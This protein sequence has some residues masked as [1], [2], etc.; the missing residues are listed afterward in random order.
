MVGR[1]RELGVLR[2]VYATAASAPAA[3]VVLGEAGIGKSRLVREF[4]DELPPGRAIWGHCLQLAG[5][6]LPF[7]A[8]ED[9][10]HQLPGVEDADEEP[11]PGPA[12]SRQRQFERWLDR[13]ESLGDDSGAA[14]LVIEDLH[15][16]D[17]STLDFI[18]YVGRSL[19]RRRLLLILTRRDDQLQVT[20][21]VLESLAELVR[22]PHVVP[23][24]LERLSASEASELA[25]TVCGDAVHPTVA[26]RLYDRSEGNPYLL[27][28][29][30]A[31]SGEVASHVQ[32]VLLARV[33]GFDEDARLLIRLA[34]VAGVSVND[35]VLWHTSG[36]DADRYLSAVRASV[37]AGVLLTEGGRYVFRH[38][39]AREAILGQLLPLEQRRFHASLAAALEKEGAASDPMTLAAVAGHWFAAGE[40]ERAFRASLAAARQAYAAH[41]YAEGWHHYRRAVEALDA[42][43]PGGESISALLVEAAEGARWA[44]DLTAAVRLLRRGL[45]RIDDAT[46][47]ARLHERLGRYLWEGGDSAESHSAYSAAVMLLAGQPDS[48]VRASVLAAQARAS[49][50]MTQYSRAADEARQAIDAARRWQARAAEGD[51]S[52]TLGVVLAVLGRGD[53]IEHLQHALALSRESEDLEATCRAFA[54]LAFVLEYAGR[55]DEACDVALDGLRVIGVHG[56]ELGTGAALATNAAAILVA[57][58][59]Y[60]ECDELLR[61]LLSRAPLQGQ[62]LQLYVERAASELARGRSDAAQSS[63]A[64]AAELA[65]AA[66]DPW[67]V[68]SLSLVQAELLLNQNCY[69][70]ARETVATSLRRLADSEE[71]NLRARLCRI[72]LRIEAD[73]VAAMPRRTSVSAGPD[74]AAWLSHQLPAN[75]P[76]V[77][78]ADLTAECLTAGA[79]HARVLRKDTW[80]DWHD[81]AEWWSRAQRPLDTAYCRLREAERA[82]DRRL[83]RQAAVAADQAAQLAR[84]IGAQPIL[85]RVAALL[86][87]ARLPNVAAAPPP[88]PTDGLASLGLTCRER[89]VLELVTR[90]ATNRE[91]GRELFI[92]ERTAAVHVSSLLRKLQVDNRVQAAAFVATQGQG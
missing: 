60:D 52:C 31:A 46:E 13:I 90:G 86:V 50:T 16:A 38:S 30:A 37:D 19:P 9:A 40:T 64:A 55:H 83:A 84:R 47:Q 81:A 3:V 2:D 57:R 18:T 5:E 20:P 61:G 6:P 63:L 36:F 43:T 92:S 62:A 87:R 89:Q 41:S 29:L 91:I 65:R 27:L 66:D 14:V 75:A 49:L 42:T 74:H 80:Q 58:G 51:A 23:V 7:A 79:E 69:D 39:L 24:Q 35:G 34:A 71:D 8:I 4:V 67:V 25:A 59:R 48:P 72:G 54:N 10:V 82:A 15:W 68:T 73:R 56:L 28:E 33:R 26:G 53:G 1:R 78:P 77:S 45:D 22:L 17:T 70:E 76:G 44:G 88:A 32:D 85:D 21:E 12:V 11:T